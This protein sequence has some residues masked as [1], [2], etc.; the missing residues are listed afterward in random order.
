MK[1]EGNFEIVKQD[2]VKEYVNGDVVLGELLDQFYAPDL[3]ISEQYELYRQLRH[4][5]DGEEL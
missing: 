5:I 4:E 2:I 1:F 3:T